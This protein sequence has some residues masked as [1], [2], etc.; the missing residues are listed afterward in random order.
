MADWRD[1]ESICIP[2]PYCGGTG[3]ALAEI[4]NLGEP[5]RTFS[6]NEAHEYTNLPADAQGTTTCPHCEGWGN[7]YTD[8]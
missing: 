1:P 8:A 7:I 2:C 4:D 5:I 3:H 6:E